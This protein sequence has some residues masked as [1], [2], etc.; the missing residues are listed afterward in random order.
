MA[1]R[2]PARIRPEILVLFALFMPGILICAGA[3][4]GPTKTPASGDRSVVPYAVST[5]RASKDPSSSRLPSPEYAGNIRIFGARYVTLRTLAGYAYGMQERRILGGPAWLDSKRFDIKAKADEADLAVP[6][7]LT[8]GLQQKYNLRQ[9]QLLLEDRF[10][11]KMHTEHREIP[12]YGLV[13]AKGGP[14]MRSADDKSSLE[15]LGVHDLPNS[16]MPGIRRVDR[17]RIIGI[18]S[19]MDRLASSLASFAGGDLDRPVV[20]MTGLTGSYDFQ[21]MWMPE[22]ETTSDQTDSSRP[23]LFTALT[24][25]LGLKLEPKKDSM[26]VLVIDHVEMPTEN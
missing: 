25:Q 4:V 15:M 20:N 19:N 24:E 7:A 14:K 3:Q 1:N 23:D 18:G 21:L 12:V 16:G 17:G 9:I 11:L 26:E 22:P 10:G 6:K 5:V 8:T 13:L 2:R